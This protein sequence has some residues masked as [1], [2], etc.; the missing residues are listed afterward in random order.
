MDSDPLSLA[1][2]YW[3]YFLLSVLPFFNCVSFKFE[4]LQPASKTCI[5]GTQ[6]GT[7]RDKTGVESER[8]PNGLSMTNISFLASAEPSPSFGYPGRAPHVSVGLPVYN[9][10]KFL[11]QAIESILCQSFGDLE[12]IISDNASTDSTQEICEGYAR[13]DHRIIYFR[14]PA[15]VGV[16]GNW[17]FVAEKARGK[18]FKW[19]SAN[20]F[21]DPQFLAKTLAVLEQDESAVLCYGRTWLVDETTNERQLYRYDTAVTDDRPSARF[22][23]VCRTFKL[24]NPQSGLFRLD[25]LRQTRLNRPYPASDMVL[26]AELALFGHF[27]MV[28]DVLLYRRIGGHTFSSRLSKREIQEV[29]FPDNARSVDYRELRRYLDYLQTIARTPIT[30]IEKVRSFAAVAHQAYWA[31]HD[32]LGESRVLLR[33]IWSRD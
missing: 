2:F 20:D 18:F 27:R 13:T 25:V 29:F 23:R 14:K 17:N 21:V 9:G 19:A 16:T 26:L 33:R 5:H 28:P 22:A 12:L 32:L 10:A 3:Y 8:G 24:N 1:K 31:R 11:A 4:R 6:L 15:N 7:Q 30:A